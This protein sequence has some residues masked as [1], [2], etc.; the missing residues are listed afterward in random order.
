MILQAKIK[1]KI[2]SISHLHFV[3]DQ[4]QALDE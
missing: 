2:T 1:L 4:F 3:T